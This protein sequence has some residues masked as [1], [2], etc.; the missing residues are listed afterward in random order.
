MPELFLSNY[1]VH[2]YDE[3]KKYQMRTSAS[4][5]VVYSNQTNSLGWGR[6]G[7]GDS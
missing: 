1:I 2:K 3:N 5:P 6:V 7:D 4:F